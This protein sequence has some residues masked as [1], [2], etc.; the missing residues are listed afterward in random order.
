MHF[1]RL[2]IHILNTLNIL[3][4]ITT[5]PDERPVVFWHG[6]GDS[7]KSLSMQRVFDLTREVIPDIF[8]HSVYIEEDN[9]K[10]QRAS[11]IG[12]ATAHVESVC[13]QLN[14]IKELEN[15][16]DMIGFSQGGLF[17]RAA[18]EKCGLKVHNLI[19]FGSP[20]AGVYDLP[21]CPD[22]D[23]ICERR[24]KLLK[25][26]VYNK[27]VQGS[28]ISAQYFRDTLNYDTYLEKSAFLADINNEKPE[29]KNQTYSDNLSRIDRLV[30]IQ[31]EQDETLLPKES[32]W[33]YDSDK[34]TRLN[35]PFDQSEFYKND[36]VGLKKLYDESRID[37]FSVDDQHMRFNDEFFKGIVEKYVGTTTKQVSAELSDNQI[38]HVDIDNVLSV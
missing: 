25:S 32:A 15:G 6:M 10:D 17:A 3:K 24:N 38:H 11:I 18:I 30:L 21:K 27:N 26:Q 13:E 22:N 2:S 8:I 20:H 14:D 23:W 1:G 12:N 4:K 36:C 34:M 35:I 29:S 19:T 28:V 5:T 33:F 7:H 16:F 31:F 37:Y 9:Y